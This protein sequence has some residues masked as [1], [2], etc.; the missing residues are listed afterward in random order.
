VRRGSVVLGVV[1]LTLAAGCG[2]PERE[3]PPEAVVLWES[4]PREPEFPLPPEARWMPACQRLRSAAEAGEGTA[5]RWACFSGGSFEEVLRF[6]AERFGTDSR[7][8]PVEHR[9]A[10]SASGPPSAAG[11]GGRPAG[12]ERMVRVAEL[13]PAEGLPLVRLESPFFD[14]DAGALRDGTLISMRWRPAGEAP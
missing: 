14:P 7:K 2:G 1:L 9:P 5:Y 6:Y 10:G 8:I 12:R 13:G 4:G 11:S 3:R